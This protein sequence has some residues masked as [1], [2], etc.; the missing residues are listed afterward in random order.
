MSKYLVAFVARH[1][2]TR[3][4]HTYTHYGGGLESNND[5]TSNRD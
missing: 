2:F 3:Q 4:G 5:V 1:I